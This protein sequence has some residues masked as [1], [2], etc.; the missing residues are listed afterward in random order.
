MCVLGS[1]SSKFLVQNILKKEKP[2][3]I[4][5]TAAYKH[6]SFVQ[7]NIQ[8][9]FINNVFGTSILV[10]ECIKN[11]INHFVNISTDKAV[12]SKNIMGL[13]KRLSE[14]LIQSISKKADNTKFSIV[15]FGNVIGSSGSV[16]P[17]FKKQ[18]KEKGPVTVSHPEVKRY[19][20]SISEAAQ[21]VM[22]SSSLGKNGDIFI[23]EMGRPVSIYELANK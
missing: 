12:R 15:R 19:F 13:T 18:I 17:I 14:M 10:D 21:L 11:N 22:Q 23:L 7:Q 20:M 8:E 9:S 5:H 4:F 1:I 2:H 16:V 3:I 6:V